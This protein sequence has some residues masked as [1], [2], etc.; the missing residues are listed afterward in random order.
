[1]GVLPS[2]RDRIGN[3]V[4]D[5]DIMIGEAEITNDRRVAVA[6]HNRIVAP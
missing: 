4:N 2:R 5:I 6:T 3:V 1:L